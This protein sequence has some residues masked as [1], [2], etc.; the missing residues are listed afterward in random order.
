RDASGRGARL[1]G[2]VGRAN[3]GAVLE[4]ANRLV[5]AGDDGVTRLHAGQHLEVFLARDTDAH[6]PEAG[7][8]AVDDEDALDVLRAPPCGGVGAGV[9]RA[10]RGGIRGGID[11]V[12]A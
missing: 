6:R 4:V 1:G 7:D 9:R 11:A 2:A 5:A 8:T 3:P 12:A 10:A